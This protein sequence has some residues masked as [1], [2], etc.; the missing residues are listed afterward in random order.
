MRIVDDQGRRRRINGVE[1]QVDALDAEVEEVV[2]TDELR[3]HHHWPTLPVRP[4]ARDAGAMPDNSP[5][6]PRRPPPR[7]GTAGRLCEQIEPS[8][9]FRSHRRPT[10]GGIA[11]RSPEPIRWRGGISRRTRRHRDR[12]QPRHRRRDRP[13]LRRRRG[14]RRRH[15]AHDRGR[16]ERVRG[17]DPRDR[18]VDRRRRRRRRADRRQ[19]RPPRGPGPH[20][21]GDRAPA[22]PGRRARQQ[23]RRHLVRRRRDVPGEALPDDVRGAGAGAVRAVAA[24]AAGHARPPVGR[25]PQH[26]VEGRRPPGRAAVRPR[27]RHAPCTAW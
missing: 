24:R 17:H 10:D 5:N 9:R 1:A 7:S 26:L 11:G 23:R 18:A 3:S 21:R 14:P 6:V 8:C 25:H 16:P 2:G 12:R 22:R 4:T 27:P 19:P 20:R 13:P 15:G